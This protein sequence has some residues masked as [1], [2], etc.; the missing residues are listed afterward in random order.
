MLAGRCLS[1]LRLALWTRPRHVMPLVRDQT[2]QLSA[3]F[4]VSVVGSTVLDKVFD[5]FFLRVVIIDLSITLCQLQPTFDC[6][7]RRYAPAVSQ[8]RVEVYI[9]ACL[10]LGSTHP[11]QFVGITPFP[12]VMTHFLSVQVVDPST[13]RLLRRVFEGL[14]REGEMAVQAPLART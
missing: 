3:Y 9:P 7:I 10:T 1:D 13:K 12:V 4:D 14:L 8:Q 11:N 6:E 5:A 2:N